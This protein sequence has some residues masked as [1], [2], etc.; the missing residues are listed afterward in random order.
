ENPDEGP[1]DEGEDRLERGEQDRRSLRGGESDRPG[2]HLAE[3]HV[4]EG[5][6][7]QRDGDADDPTGRLGQGAVLE[8]ALDHRPDRRL[9]QPAEQQRQHRDAE[10]AGGELEVERTHLR[11]RRGGAEPAVADQLLDA[12]ASSCEQGDLDRD[13]EGV[14]DD[15]RGAQQGHAVP[16]HD[17]PLPSSGRPP[18]SSRVRAASPSPLSGSHPGGG[19][20]SRTTATRR[21]SISAT[22][23]DQPRSL[24]PS[25]TSGTEPRTFNT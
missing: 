18:L 17:G 24:K 8:P 13:E 20:T 1:Q 7:H 22:S 9:D 10:L 11:Q 5:D 4:Q 19:A 3:H 21:W 16:A 2:D 6:D 23:T 14:A 15:Q 12:L 25:P